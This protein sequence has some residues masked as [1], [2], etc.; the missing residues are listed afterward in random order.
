MHGHG[1]PHQ[2]IR[3]TDPAGVQVRSDSPYKTLKELVDAVHAAR[4]APVGRAA[5]PVLTARA[6]TSICK[7]CG[8]CS[9][10]TW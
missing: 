4:L 2:G 10:R 8:S 3:Y 7:R 6:W 9:I 5:D 1:A